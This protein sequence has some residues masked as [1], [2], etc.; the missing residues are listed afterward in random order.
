MKQKIID[1]WDTIMNLLETNY[2]M[3][4]VIVDTWIKTLTVYKVEGK[5]VFM[6]V[7]PSR[8]KHGVEYIKSKGYDMYLISAIMEVLGTTELEIVIDEKENVGDLNSSQGTMG[9]G[10]LDKNYY[11]RMVQELGLK[12]EYTFE[13]FVV[14]DS[15]KMAYVTCTAVADLPGQSHLN[16]LFL[17]GESGV[18]KTHLIQSVAH[19]ILQHSPQLKVLYV[20]AEIFVNDIVT[21]IAQRTTET[22]KEKYRTVDVLIIDD[23]Q[24]I[25]GKEATQTE[26]FNTFNVLHS[27]GKQIILSSDKPPSEMKT[28]ED[29]LRSRFEWGVPIDIHEPD[30]E[31]RMAILKNKAEKK[32]LNDIPDDV[33]V[34]IAENIVTNV[35]EL[36]SALNTLYVYR[37]LDNKEVTL[38]LAQT[39]LRDLMSKD[40][41]QEITPDVIM[42]V[43]GEHLG[44]SVDDIKSKKRTQSIAQARQISMYLCRAL[45]DKGLKDIGEALGGKDHST[46]INGIKRVEEK[47]KVDAE[48][49]AQLDIIKKKIGV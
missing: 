15:N 28:L 30:Y 43:V 39:I 20:P 34:Y 11:S 49:D 35:R 9:A 45:T 42:S 48:F 5:T 4:R 31:T 18:G 17:Y 37:S 22:V 33:F 25:I 36:E 29:R 14:G 6:Y 46:V 16:P 44:V 38:E 47:M 23:I 13:N 24:E 27:A 32:K 40:A 8:G 19:Y 10:Y 7:Q 12:T 41:K 2:D 3:S 26:F 1:N 21:S